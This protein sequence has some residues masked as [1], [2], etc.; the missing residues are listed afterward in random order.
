MEGHNSD[1]DYVENYDGIGYWATEVKRTERVVEIRVGEILN[2]VV[3]RE[4]EIGMRGQEPSNRV[5][6]NNNSDK[7]NVEKP[8]VVQGC[9]DIEQFEIIK[10]VGKGE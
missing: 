9:L 6:G 2:E 5:L 4:V 1:K 10:T 3:D 8:D 7:D